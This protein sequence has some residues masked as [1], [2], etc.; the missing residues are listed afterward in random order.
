MAVAPLPVSAQTA[1]GTPSVGG[2]VPG[3]TG[4]G[5]PPPAPSPAAASGLWERA[6]LLG[7]IGGLRSFL[8][9]YGIAF[10]LNET[11]EAL[12]NL[13]GGTARGAIYDGLTQVS[14]GIDLNTAIGLPGGIA[15]ISALQIHGRGLSSNDIDNLD[16]VSSIEADR[17]TRLFEWWVQQSFLG[18]KADVKLGQQSADL[19]FATSQYGGLFVNASFGWNTLSAVDLPSGGPAYP[20]ATP[21]V[22]LRVQ[23]TSRLG[24]LLAIL[25]GSPAGLGTGDPQRRDPSG[26]NFDLASGVFAIGELQAAAG[27]TG[28]YKLGAWYN[29]NA[30][31]DQF[32]VASPINAAGAPRRHHNDWS[33]YGAFDQLVFRPAGAKEGGAGLFLRAAGAPGDRNQ[34]NVFA[35]G[36]VT[37]KGAFGRADDTMGIGVLWT[38]ISDNARA[39]DAAASSLDGGLTPIRSS[40]TVLELTYQAQITPWWIVQPDFQRVFDPGGGIQ[41]PRRPTRQIGDA[42]V[43]GLRTSVTF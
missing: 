33:V 40:E 11:S 32:F 38:R 26:T 9:Q 34:V 36:G 37:Y 18:G 15:N 7:D 39:A 27:Q 24:F 16:L 30:F 1:P 3:Q 41:D 19:E 35:D 8:G 43:F 21:G 28:A 12:G 23:P 10:G 6:A 22:R 29:S 5:A 42:T 25:N 13:A 17:S 20:L 14:L 4:A 31:T 2:T